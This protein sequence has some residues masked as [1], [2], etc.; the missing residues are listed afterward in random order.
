METYFL[1]KPQVRSC[2]MSERGKVITNWPDIVDIV[3]KIKEMASII[4][5]AC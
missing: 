1:S 3:D 5:I 4:D 2:G